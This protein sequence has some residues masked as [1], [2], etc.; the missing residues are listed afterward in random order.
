MKK[1][2]YPVLLVMMTLLMASLSLYAQKKGQS[3]YEP[4]QDFQKPVFAGI[5]GALEYYKLIRNNQE[6]GE[7]SYE[8]FAAARAQVESMGTN[9]NSTLTW[10]NIG[11]VDQGGRVRAMLFDRND[12]NVM[13][14]GAVSG[15]LWKTTNGGQSWFAIDDV[16][17]SLII[18]C[19]AQASD[20]TVYFG[21]G[22]GFAPAFGSTAGSTG[23]VGVGL[24]KATSPANT[25]FEQVTST[26][27]NSSNG[28]HYI[29]NLKIHP[30][31][32]IYAATHK[33]VMRSSD[34]G[35]TWDNPLASIG[36]PGT[37]FAHDVD[38]ST[39]GSVI[40]LVVGRKAYISTDGG[41][42]Y[43]NVSTGGTMLPTAGVS[44]VEIDIAPSNAN[45]IYASISKSSN[46]S[47]LNVYRSTNKGA[48]WEIIGPGGSETFN[49]LGTQGF[50]DNVIKVHPTNPNKIYLGGLDMWTWENG[51]NW[52]QKSLWFLSE[53][54]PSF[55]HADHHEYIFHPQ[56]P[57]I[58]YFG[59]D[60][61]ISKSTSGGNSFET[62][63]RNFVTLQNYAIAVSKEGQIMSGTQD[64]G[65][66]LM[67]RD[68][69]VEG[70]SE[71]LLGGDGGFCSFSFLNDKLYFGSIYYGAVY[72]TPTGSPDGFA[73][74]WDE[75]VQGLSN[76]GT[77]AFASFVTPLVLHE[78]IDDYL[79]PDSTEYTHV[80]TPVYAGDT[81][82]VPSGTSGY[83]FPYVLP[84]EV[85]SL[86]EDDKITVQD[87]VTS[88]FYVGITGQVLM[89][90]EA[91]NF[92]SQPAWWTIATIS[93]QVQSMSVSKCGNYLF[94]GTS[95]GNLYR[96]SNLNYANDMESASYYDLSVASPYPVNPYS[97]VET[98]KLT[99]ASGGRPINKIAID[100]NDPSRIVV[101]L[102]SYGNSQYVYYSSN[103]LNAEP[104]FTAKQ[105]TTLP[106]VPVY[107]AIIDLSNPNTVLLGTEYGI[108][109]TTN[110]TASPPVWTE[111][112]AGGIARVPV[113][114]L[115]QQI[116]WLPGVT[117]YGVVYAG[118][119][120]RGVFESFDFV[121]VPE[122]ETNTIKQ[123]LLEVYPNP[124]EDQ[125]FVNIP[126]GSHVTGARIFNINGKVVSQ[127]N[128]DPAIKTARFDVSSL[129]SGVYFIE[130]IDS[131]SK[132]IG[133]FIK[134]N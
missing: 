65:T 99:I 116:Y 74:F 113:Y 112:N 89:T 19:I 38:I 96:I 100:P 3:R 134:A 130:L 63:N 37:S 27:P 51:G 75:Y 21:T 25:S 39:D 103:A 70:R 28:W 60:G 127:I 32:D 40:S 62:T 88:K 13:Y 64:N 23:F 91:H 118:T 22:E 6:T 79:S 26:T 81:I 35:T 111:E 128:V 17:Q 12:P 95:N 67:K 72:R 41:S 68:G 8:D 9:K 129:P 78:K 115:K 7:L 4:R 49:P 14:V 80:G 106:Q 54:S 18:S 33:G 108:Y 102:G 43:T 34:G 20:G 124:V 11:P 120:G 56:N 98:K 92:A 10:R 93:G 77:S 126:E 58:M 16:M 42:N 73:E 101:V 57:N 44:R 107:S 2:N 5:T 29:Y 83:L 82:M 121:S 1:K 30:N 48:S 24:F 31:G 61:G 133:K 94:V 110:I 15:G 55:L 52:E 50:Y 36:A 46:E 109:M 86:V 59:T 117:N 104:T 84:V 53:F 119:H 69:F 47:L 45:Y 97:V 125:L 123:K 114:D 132:H 131:Q 76:F 90:R 87:I 122:H 105:G 71:P 66:L 85:D